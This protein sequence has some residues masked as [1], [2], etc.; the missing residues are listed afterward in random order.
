MPSHRAHALALIAVTAL[1]PGCVYYGSKSR[2]VDRT[3][4]VDTGVGATIMMPGQS[5]P[6]FPG[7]TSSTT[8]A[9]AGDPAQPGSG[10][11]SGSSS[12]TPSGGGG[13]LTMIGGTRVDETTHSS[14]HE[15][16]IW[17]K[18]LTLPFAVVAAPFVAAADAMR[19][20]EQPGPEV[21]RVDPPRPQLAA[22]PPGGSYDD[23]MI[24]GLERELE[25]RQ[26]A[27]PSSGSAASPR[28]AAITGAAPSIADELAA[29]QRTPEAAPAPAR[30]QASAP[31]QTG[32]PSP[33]ALRAP[34]A[35]TAAADGIVDRNE[36][37]RI[38]LWIYRENGEIVRRVMDEDFD[39]RPDQ[40][41]FYDTSTH[42]VSRVEEDTDKDGNVDNWT[43]YQDGE[44]ARRRGDT[45]HDGAVDTWT[46]Y[47]KG[48]VTRHEQDTTG[49]GFR[50][51]IGFYENGKLVR[52]EQDTTGSGRADVIVHYDANEKL[53]R[54][55]ED[56]DRDGR[57]DV[58]S[59]YENGRLSR[60]ELID[61]TAQ[62]PQ[63]GAS[64]ATP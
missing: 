38:D 3:P 37:G 2:D 1:A 54:R 21:P 35:A 17:F 28:G 10:S 44:I 30:P 24:D 63:P 33:G 41:I 61:G 13:G 27:A 50:D 14:S 59:Y 43:D 11:Y 34:A 18:Y 53:V 23:R 29:L 47:R 16:P 36:D 25:Q 20:E 48:E 57:I 64:R 9:G 19:G 62:A 58:I 56:T 4:I 31:T 26:A 6:A 5:A 45:N 51:R 52:E 46:F 32:A 40:S 12:G 8:G 22:K 60:R 42:R 15:E 7:G 49:N 55:D 39:G